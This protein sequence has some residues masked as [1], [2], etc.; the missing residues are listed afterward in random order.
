MIGETILEVGAEGGTLTLFG[1]RSADGQWRF[2]TH[3]NESNYRE[4]LDE[5]DLRGSGSLVN[6]S[7]SVSSL[8]E[9]LALLERH[10]WHRM[11]PLQI[12]PEFRTAILS[13]AQKRATQEE[14]AA[15]SSNALFR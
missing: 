12:H 5:A 11:M 6:T 1:S 13:E 9:A 10:Q 7:E 2:W 14:V 4:L 3:T 8:I 15:W